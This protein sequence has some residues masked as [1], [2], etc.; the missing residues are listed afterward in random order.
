MKNLRFYFYLL[1]ELFLIVASI[2][3][4][5]WTIAS[6]VWMVAIAIKFDDY[7]SCVRSMRLIRRINQQITA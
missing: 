4:Y 7:R 5:G 2:K 3:A 6:L 1:L